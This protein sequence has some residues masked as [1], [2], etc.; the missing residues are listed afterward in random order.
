MTVDSPMD[1]T[2]VPALVAGKPSGQTMAVKR[3]DER[4]YSA[5][6]KMN[7][8]PLTTSSATLSADG[9]T[10]TVESVNQ[11]GGKNETFIETWVKK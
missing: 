3:I 2:E 7:G 6:V 11:L 5:I 4:H 1:G 9:K 10:L 8:K